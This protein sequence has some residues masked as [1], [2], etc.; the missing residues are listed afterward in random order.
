MYYIE[1]D[2]KTDK[3]KTILE[4]VKKLKPT[5]KEAKVEKKSFRK[6]TDIEM[7]LPGDLN[8]TEEQLEEFFSRKDPGKGI[9]LEE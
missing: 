8:P 1:V 5:K 3:G 7:A 2:E 9:T 4:F 6:L